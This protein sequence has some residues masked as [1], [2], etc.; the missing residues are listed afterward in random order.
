M[1]YSNTIFIL[2]RKS[3]R[4]LRITSLL[5]KFLYGTGYEQNVNQA[6]Q[7]SVKQ[8]HVVWD[9]GANIG[10]Y[11]SIFSDLVGKKGKVYAFEPHPKTF[12][13][14]KALSER[15]NIIFLNI[16]LSNTKGEAIFTEK[17]NNTVNSIVDNSY[18]GDTISIATDTAD[19]I[20]ENKTAYVPNFI[21]IDVEGYE[22]FVLLGMKSLL[23]EK[24][25]KYLLIE[26]HHSIMDE[27]KLPNGVKDIVNLLTVNG[28]K[29]NWIDPSH[30][31]ADRHWIYQ[32][33]LLRECHFTLDSPEEII[34]GKV[35]GDQMDKVAYNSAEKW[36]RSLQPLSYVTIE[37]E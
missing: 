29:V 21:K 19:N 10:L 23:S 8:D 2:L 37:I 5:A 33:N 12:N 32:N 11:T 27:L 16:G 20:I 35:L 34:E 13:E 6:I 9:I 17:E 22:L 25:L 28:F 4:K 7:K 15:S 36:L 30:I 14:L 3:L 26:V 31:F 24:N 18:I 1:D